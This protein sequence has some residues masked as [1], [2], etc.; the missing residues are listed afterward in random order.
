MS[1]ISFFEDAG[2]RAEVI[3]DS[4]KLS[5]LSRLTS[6]QKNQV[7]EFAREHKAAILAAM[8]QGS[9]PGECESCPAAG[10]WDHG[11]YA[12]NGLMCF[13]TAYFLHK[14]GSP[15]PCKYMRNECPL[16]GKKESYD[17]SH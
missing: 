9:Q 2:V 15:T 6:E 4:I 3:G 13:H 12:G 11:E 1:A 16:N 14:A 8:A 7:I 10:Y 5:G 17:D